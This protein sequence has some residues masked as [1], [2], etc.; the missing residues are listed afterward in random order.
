[1]PPQQARRLD[2]TPVLPR[3]GA[4]ATGVAVAAV[5]F[6]VLLAVGLV[7]LIG[8]DLPV[9]GTV[10]DPAGALL[11]IVKVSLG[12]A[13]GAGAVVALVVAYRR[14]LIGE[15]ESH[16]ADERLFTERFTTAAEQLG[17]EKAAVRLAGVY[18]MARLADDWDEQRQTCIDVL[19]A[20]LRMPYEPEG[21]ASSGE[22]EVRLTVIR[23]IRAHLQGDD[24]N[25]QPSWIGHDLDFTGAVFDGG[26]FSGSTLTGT[27]KFTGAEFIDGQ[28]SF[29]RAEF[30]G[31]LVSFARAR[32]SGALVS[33]GGAKFIG[34]DVSFDGAEFSGGEVSFLGAMFSGGEVSFAHAMFTGGQVPFARARFSGGLVSFGGAKFIGGQVT[35]AR[36]EFSDGEVSFSDAEFS[37]AQVP[38]VGAM[39]SGGHVR[40]SAAM[41]S[42]GEVSFLGAMF[43]GGEVTFAHAMFTGGQ[44]WFRGAEF[45][46]GQV[47]F[48]GAKFIGSDVSFDGAEF[49]GGE[50]D[51][52]GHAQSR[53]PPTGIPDP[54]PPSLLLT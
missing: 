43:S 17:H 48:I 26:D 38:F 23:V 30:S 54:A 3:L 9:T 16:R 29:T 52:R 12:I 37:G 45:T 41:F 47:S 14:Q 53:C 8:L 19:C 46:A 34:A 21:A 25:G 1:V 20:Y 6:T 42:S 7:W 39:F 11:D 49:S 4:V 13:A 51:L 36:A 27:T 35:F 32:F 10:A 50:V 33:F 22:R 5:L 15:T 24:S 31:G 40:F 44:V 2:R 28:V 18:A